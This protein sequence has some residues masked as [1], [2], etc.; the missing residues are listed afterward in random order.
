MKKKSTG[1]GLVIPS[2][3]HIAGMTFY[4]RQGQVISRVSN[5]MERRSNT[6]PQFVQR[7]KMRHTTALWKMLRFCEVM[8]TERRNA[9]QNFM[10]LANRL[11]AVYVPKWMSDASFLMSGIPMSDGI[12]PTVKQQLGEVDGVPAL[13]TDLQA[14]E[15]VRDERLLFYTAEQNIEHNLPRVRFSMRELPRLNMTVVDGHLALVGEEFAD[16]MKGWALVKII[17]NRCSPQT[18]VTRCT[19]YEQY[20]TD[21]ALQTA[22]KSYDGL[23][24]NL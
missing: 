11:R 12:L 10:S 19:F 5:S 18:I 22:V 14:N 15:W 6:L 21:K 9:C 20:T 2:K 8:F 16:E 3:L 24:K 17:G 4:Q 7:Q 23:T 13:I 1:M